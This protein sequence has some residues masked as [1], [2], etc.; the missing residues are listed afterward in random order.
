MSIKKLTEQ[1]LIELANQATE[2]ELKPLTQFELFM[3][4]VGAGTGKDWVDAQLIYWCYLKWCE[5]KNIIPKSRYHFSRGIA[6]FYKRIPDKGTVYYVMNKEPFVVSDDERWAMRRD[7]RQERVYKPWHRKKVK[8]AKAA[9][10]ASKQK[11][12]LRKKALKEAQKKN[13]E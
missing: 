8:A 7:W 5:E 11:A 13:G 6:K 1:E 4:D 2:E 12:K 9:G 3:K 10:K